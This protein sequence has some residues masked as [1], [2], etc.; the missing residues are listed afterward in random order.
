MALIQCGECGNSVSDRAPACPKCGAPVAAE[1]RAD[2]AATGAPVTTIQQTSKAFKKQQVY[3]TLLT[4]F[5]IVA[6]IAGQGSATVFMLAL[7]G[8]LAGLVWL[9]TVR[10]RTW[11]H[12]G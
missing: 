2:Q 8:A 6:M 3:A 1:A 12:H 10:I 7:T 4:V 5:S 9:I 11:W